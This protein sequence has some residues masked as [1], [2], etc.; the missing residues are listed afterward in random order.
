MRDFQLCLFP[1]FG[2][3]HFKTFGTA[4]FKTFGTAFDKTF[5]L[6][7]LDGVFLDHDIGEVL[8]VGVAFTTR[9]LRLR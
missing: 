9:T 2:A 1:A 5:P 4:H 7:I 8:I 3:A 6:G